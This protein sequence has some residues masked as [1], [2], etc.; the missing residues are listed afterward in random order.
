MSISDLV[1]YRRSGFIFMKESEI[2]KKIKT[3]L[4]EFGW[5]IVKLIQTNLNGI[6]D[7]L[8]LRNG[9]AV[10]IEVKSEDGEISHLQLYRIEKIEEQNFKVIIATSLQDIEYL[11]K[12]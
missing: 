11:C 12:N 1:A 10:F 2:Q 6:P 3:R 8:C 4:E 9:V 5:I 7:L